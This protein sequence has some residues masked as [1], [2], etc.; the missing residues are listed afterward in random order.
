[1]TSLADLA[2]QVDWPDHDAATTAHDVLFARPDLGRLAGEIEWLA[3]ARGAYPVHAILRPR[4][5]LVAADHAVAATGVS[6][7]SPT[8]TQDTLAAI[9]AGSAPLCE[10]ARQNG[11]GIVTEGLPPGLSAEAAIER[12]AAL[13]DAEIDS[14]ADLIIVGNIGAGSTC[15][16]AA[17]VAV[18][19]ATEPVKVVGR[20]GSQI[21]DLGWMLKASAIRDARR[22]GWPLR[23]DPTQLLNALDCADVAL[24]AGLLLRTAARRT[25]VLLDGLVSAAAALAADTA[26]SGARRWW[27]IAQLTGEPAQA[28]VAR[29]FATEPIVDLSMA[30][31]DGAGGLIALGVVR[32][33]LVLS[34]AA[35]SADV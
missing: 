28:I 29:T 9:S 15:T 5:I 24:L 33:G 32:A 11:T 34:G 3:G 23:D 4:L 30:S 27:Q 7:F 10:L 20:G 6:R 8:D 25:P 14:G 2:A 12:G 16:A 22:R 19:C 31:G 13:A 17:V 35:S 21:D 18:L 1:M 26:R